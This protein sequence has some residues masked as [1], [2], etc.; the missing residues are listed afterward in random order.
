MVWFIN[1]VIDFIIVAFAIFVIIKG[2]NSL[3]KKE[4]E[5]VNAPTEP[6]IEIKLLT[7]IRDLLKK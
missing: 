5:K 3:K 6:S 4:D 2:I 7:E 1:T